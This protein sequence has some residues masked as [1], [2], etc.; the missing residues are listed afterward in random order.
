MDILAGIIPVTFELAAGERAFP[1]HVAPHSRHHGFAQGLPEIQQIDPAAVTETPLWIR[2]TVHFRLC[3]EARMPR[4]EYT[5][6]EREAIVPKRE[7]RRKTHRQRFVS[8]RSELHGLP[9]KVPEI[10]GMLQRAPGIQ[11]NP[12]I[13]A[14]HRERCLCIVVKKP[15]VSKQ[16]TATAQFE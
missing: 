1:G 9:V 13:S 11:P 16:K 3:I 14:M 2:E 5:L 10:Q 4:A 12:E 15:A 8:L 7:L 6:L